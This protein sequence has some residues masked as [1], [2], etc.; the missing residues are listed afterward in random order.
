MKYVRDGSQNGLYNLG[1]CEVG[2]QK[3]TQFL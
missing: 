1:V 3:K 2:T